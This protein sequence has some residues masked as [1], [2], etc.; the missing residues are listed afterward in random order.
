LINQVNLLN[1]N[2]SSKKLL[3]D[4]YKSAQQVYKPRNMIG[5]ISKQRVTTKESINKSQI[6]EKKKI[7]SN[8][9]PAS[10]TDLKKTLSGSQSARKIVYSGNT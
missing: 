2:L 4:I 10:T 6:K 9:K 1:Q 5:N 3:S 8:S 7:P